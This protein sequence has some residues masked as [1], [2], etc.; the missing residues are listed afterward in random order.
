MWLCPLYILTVASR[1]PKTALIDIFICSQVVWAKV[2]GRLSE[3]V[4]KGETLVFDKLRREDAGRYMC[5]AENDIAAKRKVVAFAVIV[6]VVVVFVVVV[7]VVVVVVIVDIGCPKKR[8][9]IKVKKKI[10]KN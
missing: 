9:S 4:V 2:G 1:K 7:V 6:T 8:Y 10:T 5:L 3:E